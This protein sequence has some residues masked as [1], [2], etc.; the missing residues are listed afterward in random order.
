VPIPLGVQ[1]DRVV[2]R[3]LG[4]RIGGIHAR[5]SSIDPDL[6]L[7]VPPAIEPFRDTHAPADVI[8]RARW[9]E[10]DAEPT[11]RLLFDSGG[12][13]KL[14]AN[15]SDRTFR[16]QS[17]HFGSRPYKEARFDRDWATGEIALHRAYFDTSQPVYPLEYPLDELL[18]VRLL[19]QRSG[20]ELHAC[21]VID[22]DRAFL[23]VG[24]SGAGKST[25]ARVWSAQCGA[26][27]LSDDRIIVR[28]DS[29]NATIHGTPWHGDEALMA[30]RSAQLAHVFILR[31]GPTARTVP[32]HGAAAV[33]QLF[34][35]TFPP[36]HS[37][38]ALAD[39]LEVLELIADRTPCSELWFRPDNSTVEHVRSLPS[40]IA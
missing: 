36:F 2:T 28:C 17:D 26:V 14:Y 3:E 24:Q 29:G 32:L 39:T 35:C 25:M 8:I 18:C 10:I 5:M 22:G 19:A 4:W 38:R 12:L 31:Q 7:L 20:V 23:F 11:G 15:G 37:A 9:A 34:S 40:A 1:L 33:A 30:A 16:F 13:W 6:A 21:G 27:V